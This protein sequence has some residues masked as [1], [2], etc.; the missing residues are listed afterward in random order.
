MGRS[1]FARLVPLAVGTALLVLLAILGTLQYRW[2]GQVS[3]LESQRLRAA[4]FGAGA[5]FAEDFDH[6]VTRAFVLFR[7]PAPA[8]EVAAPMAMS[9]PVPEV[10]AAPVTPA[11]QAPVAAGPDAQLAA[12]VARQYAAWRAET[13]FPELIRDIFYVGADPGPAGGAADGAA[14]AP[15]L[16]ILQGSPPRFVAAAWPPE[17]AGL[18]RRLGRQG[19]RDRDGDGDGRGGA[20]LPPVAPDVPGLLIPAWWRS[21]GGAVDPGG[22]RPAPLPGGYLIVRF[23]A[24][25][26]SSEILPELTRRHFGSLKGLHDAVAVLENAENA[27]IAENAESVA[28]VPDR[29]SVPGGGANVSG[30]ASV[31]SGGANVHGGA[32]R[33]RPHVVFLSD[34]T[35]P[36]DDFRAGDLALP[37]FAVRHVTEH[38]TAAAADSAVPAGQHP[39]PAAADAPHGT[40]PVATHHG[41][42]HREPGPGRMRADGMDQLFGMPQGPPGQGQGP[43]GPRGPRGAWTLVVRRRGGSLDEMVAAFRRRNLAIGAGIVALAAVTTAL[44]T[45]ATQRAQRL[46]RQQMEFVAAVT[47]ELNTPLTAIRSAGQNL[48]DGV[49][50]EPAQVR[51]YGDLILGEGRRLSR[52]VSQVLDYAGIESGRQAYALQPTAVGEAVAG[53]LED[54]RALLAERR[55]RVESDLDPR[56][57]AVVAD[58][59]ALRRALRNLIENA[60]KYGGPDPWIGILAR[61]AGGEVAITVEDHGPGIRREDLPHLFEPFFRSRPTGAETPPGSGLG[62]SVV[63]RIARAHRGRV[64]C[65][66]GGGRRGSAF[67]LHLPAAAEKAT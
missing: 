55:A 19:D 39:P 64:S 56:L 24:A 5:A 35:L 27:E 30:G 31:P 18:R 52:L 65:A 36:A 63:S 44:M 47:H 48:A 16:A 33:P 41:E 57:P 26:I 32:A 54:C 8:A 22:R 20:F 50:A 43:Q 34:A 37:M 7:P 60:A 46:A 61:Q 62:L 53:A 49:V 11:A 2:I 4:L 66:S 45:I 42:R 14:N 67:T 6:E 59:A 10:P 23:D 3:I 13:P 29:V 15:A 17:L 51:R 9:V 21:P 58:P 1:G 12:R 28:G 38:G 25:A 40:P